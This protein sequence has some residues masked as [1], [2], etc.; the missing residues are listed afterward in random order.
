VPRHRQLQQRPLRRQEVVS[1][2]NDTFLAGALDNDNGN[3]VFSSMTAGPSSPLSYD[4]YYFPI[5]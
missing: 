5:P 3:W 2:V 1:I 4:T